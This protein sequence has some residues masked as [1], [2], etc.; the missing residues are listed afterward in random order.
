[1]DVYMTRDEI[2]NTTPKRLNHSND[3]NRDD[4]GPNAERLNRS[5]VVQWISK[6][7]SLVWDG[8]ESFFRHVTV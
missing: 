8:E 6:D 3:E 1:M 4:K 7:D 5:T 2:E